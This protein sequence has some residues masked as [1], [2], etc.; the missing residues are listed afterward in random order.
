MD[1]NKHVQSNEMA[2]WGKVLAA[3][4]GSVLETCVVDRTDPCKLSFDL[5]V[6]A[7][8]QRHMCAHIHMYIE[9]KCSFFF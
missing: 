3:K 6:H 1:K 2:Q 9:T 4:P 8:V 5:H 7:M